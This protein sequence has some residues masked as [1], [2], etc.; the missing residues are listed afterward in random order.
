MTFEV[1]MPDIKADSETDRIKSREQV[2][3]DIVK[4]LAELGMVSCPDEV[5]DRLMIT[6][7]N[8]EF[9]HDSEM[10]CEAFVNVL[11]SFESKNLTKNEVTQKEKQEGIIAAFLH[12]IGKSGPANVGLDCQLSVIKL[13][14]IKSKVPDQLISDSQLISETLK[15]FFPDEYDQMVEGLLQAGI[16]EEM[17][18]RTFWNKHAWWTHEI[19]LKYP[20]NISSRVDLIASSHH[21]IEGEDPCKVPRQEIPY[22]SEVIG[23]L[24]HY[25]D[26]LEGRILT[27]VDK[28]Q[29]AL[30]RGG[31]S[32]N[33]AVVYLRGVFQ[34]YKTDAVTDS[35]IEIIDELGKQDLLFPN[36]K[37]KYQKT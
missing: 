28:Y 21:I 22:E 10:I 6:E 15:T 5:I 8:S 23:A 7:E 34:K 17:T 27:I 31:I 3:L 24:E 14:S 26:L 13:F 35:I 29:A 19:L 9:N 33:D 37:S 11:A 36:T 25:V 32:H 12:D 1:A 30:V 2:R 20:D 18:M 4:K 16:S